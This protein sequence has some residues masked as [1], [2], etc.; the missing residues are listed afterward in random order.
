MF[1]LGKST[2]TASGRSGMPSGSNSLYSSFG[3]GAEASGL[4]ALPNPTPS[5]TCNGVR[6]TQ[7]AVRY[8]SSTAHVSRPA[9]RRYHSVVGKSALTPMLSSALALALTSL[10]SSSA[11]SAESLKNR[12]MSSASCVFCA[13]RDSTGCGTPR[14]STDPHIPGRASPLPMPVPS[15]KPEIPR[16]C[17][18]GSRSVT[19]ESIR[20]HGGAVRPCATQNAH[21]RSRWR[22]QRADWGELGVLRSIPAANMSRTRGLGSAADGCCWVAAFD[23][24]LEME[25]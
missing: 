12:G 3:A 17:A 2:F 10:P 23:G 20:V 19:R 14:L 15:E 5:R 8:P 11:T 24:W 18:T 16:A 25:N 22:G 6:P 1:R 7:L 21:A 9:R 4:S 13:P